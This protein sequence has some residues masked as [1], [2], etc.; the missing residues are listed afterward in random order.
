MSDIERTIDT[1]LGRMD[2]KDK[3]GQC[4]TMNFTG[5]TISD[6]EVR[7]IREFRCGGLRAWRPMRSTARP[8]RAAFGRSSAYHRRIPS[9]PER[10]WTTPWAA[11]SPNRWVDPPAS[12]VSAARAAGY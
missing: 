9:R 3:V 6:Y 7:F 12:A 5:Y 1:L 4:L 8:S 11:T 2:L 10:P